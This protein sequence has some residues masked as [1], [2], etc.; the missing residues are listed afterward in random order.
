MLT[1][2]DDLGKVTALIDGAASLTQVRVCVRG[3]PQLNSNSALL[4]MGPG[5]QLAWAWDHVFYL[6][7][8]RPGSGHMVSNIS[9][10]SASGGQGAIV[11]CDH[12]GNVVDLC[13]LPVREQSWYMIT[14]VGLLPVTRD[15]DHGSESLISVQ[16]RVRLTFCAGDAGS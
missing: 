5:V 11:V 14:V 9:G 16:D 10:K 3:S 4:N 13:L 12:S 1:E 15:R 2:K 7:S 6:H 8:L